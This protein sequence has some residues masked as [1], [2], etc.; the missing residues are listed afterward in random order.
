MAWPRRPSRGIGRCRFKRG[1]GQ[2]IQ[3]TATVILAEF[4]RLAAGWS[5][6]RG[7]QGLK[8]ASPNDVRPTSQ[9]REANF[10]AHQA[11]VPSG[12]GQISQ[13]LWAWYLTFRV[14][15]RLPTHP[16]NSGVPAT[17][18]CRRK[19][20]NRG[21]HGYSRVSGNIGGSAWGRTRNG[22]IAN[23]VLQLGGNSS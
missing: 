14:L 12:I 16:A 22:R 2:S 3:E 11:I 6:L 9:H 21:A 20:T 5:T 23:T 7:R 8:S 18:N 1:Q 13:P 4:A 10:D 17:R 15:P 19:R